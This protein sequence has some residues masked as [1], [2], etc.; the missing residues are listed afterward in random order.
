MGYSKA[1][2]AADAKYKAKNVR[3]YVVPVN[4]RTERDLHTWLERKDNKA[5]YIKSLIWDDIE[6]YKRR[7]A[8]EIERSLI[9][10]L[11]K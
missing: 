1:Q 9:N 6:E 11:Q 7:K 5:G 2:K 8:I 10:D 4:V 3:R